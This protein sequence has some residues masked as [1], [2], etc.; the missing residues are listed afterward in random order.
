MARRRQLG[1]LR[2]VEA[3]PGTDVDVGLGVVLVA[4]GYADADR[5]RV[6]L[7]AFLEADEGRDVEMMRP[8]QHR[9][10]GRA[11]ELRDELLQHVGRAAEPAG[12]LSQL[13]AEHAE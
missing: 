7:V 5:A 8:A 9:A 1:Q 6:R 10:C 13:P 3:R 11:R 12:E 4:W 2:A